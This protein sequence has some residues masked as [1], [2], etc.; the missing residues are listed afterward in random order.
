MGTQKSFTVKTADAAKTGM[1]GVGQGLWLLVSKTGTKSWVFR[2]QI[3]GKARSMGLGSYP[4]VGLAEARH[5]AQAARDQIRRDGIDPLAQK[6]EAARQAEE[7]RAKA[8]T[9]MDVAREYIAAH[10]PSWRNPKHGDQWHNTLVKYAEPV[11]GATPVAEID[12]TLVL[13]VLRPIWTTK[14]ET[15]TRVRSRIELVLDHAEAKGLRAEGM[16]NPAALAG[17]RSF[18]PPARKVATV[19]HHPAL[20]Y[21][22]MS[23]FMTALRARAGSGAR[24]LEFAVLTAA[25]SGE[26]RGA[27]WSEV[28]LGSGLWTIPATRM[29]AGR[30]HRVPLSSAALK[31]LKAQLAGTEGT[32]TPDDYIFP[33]ARAGR[34]LSD[35][36]VTAHLRGMNEQG[37]DFVDAA[38]Q[39]VTAHGFR[40]S[41]RDWAAEQTHYPAE[42]AEMAL[43]HTVGSKVE[44]A[45]R[46]GDMF[47]KR[48]Q[49][50]ADW[51]AWC[52]GGVAAADVSGVGAAPWKASARGA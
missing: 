8:A 10:R 31:L 51:A 9:C 23:V 25:R 15:A 13:E 50:M 28:D 40:S 3:A 11:F 49:M 12:R 47:E 38:G 24:A 16:R 35:M 21:Q 1:H 32:P 6:A 34:P 45:Y 33:G 19:V 30:A 48:R 29:K 2:Y 4:S 39:T 42:M 43:A 52:G 27:T 44:A 41:F 18:L 36:S 26:V 20:P 46:R 17:L 7:S 22:R 14:T 5:R 37:Q